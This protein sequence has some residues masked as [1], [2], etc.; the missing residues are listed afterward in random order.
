[1]KK[2]YGHPKFYELLEEIKE[3]HSSKNHDYAKTTDPFSNLK[4]CEEIYVKCPHCKKSH[5]IPAHIGTLIRM[6][7]KWSR[8]IQLTKK[9][10]KNESVRDSLMDLAVYSLL[11]I[12]LLEEEKK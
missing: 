5:P 12:I 1:M 4:M 9:E 3:I 11:R 10:G 7:D 2:Y 6:S 8:L